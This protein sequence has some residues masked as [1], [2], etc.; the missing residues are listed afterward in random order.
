MHTLALEAVVSAARASFRTGKVAMLID[1]AECAADWSHGKPV[2][3][4][5]LPGSDRVFEPIR[6]Q[7]NAFSP[8]NAPSY[9]PQ[10]GGWLIG[11]S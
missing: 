6:K 10:G 1:R 4:A 5:R 11:I 9:L 8:P 2:G 3:I 7:W